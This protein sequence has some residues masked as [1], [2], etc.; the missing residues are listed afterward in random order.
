V[1]RFVKCVCVNIGVLGPAGDRQRHRQLVEQGYEASLC[2]ADPFACELDACQTPSGQGAF[3]PVA[4]LN[5]STP[6][7][8]VTLFFIAY[9]SAIAFAK[10]RALLQV[11]LAISLISLT[12]GWCED[13][14]ENRAPI[15]A[16]L[17]DSPVDLT[18]GP[19]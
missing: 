11:S 5:M 3:F 13:A 2:E 16:A 10:A 17:A 19:P 15:P 8:Q 12:P 9:A 1:D 7:G 18:S 4:R 6:I 14:I